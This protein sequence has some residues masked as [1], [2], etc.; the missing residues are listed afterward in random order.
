MV[1]KIDVSNVGDDETALKP[2]NLPTVRFYPK[3]SSE[4]IDFTGDAEDV[5]EVTA[6][7][8]GQLS[9]ELRQLK[10]LA[11]DFAAA[12]G[13]ARQAALDKAAELVATLDSDMQR[14][15]KVFLVTMKRVLERGNE[16]IAT[17]K[18][19]LGKLVDSSSITKE[20]VKDFKGRLAALNA[21]G[22]L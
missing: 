16:F 22:D 2:T 8:Q 11:A 5:A 3:G 6:F 17:E 14:T 19:R 7:V 12:S 21:F 9:P 13:D 20:K 18:A 4:G 10:A 1:A 15:G